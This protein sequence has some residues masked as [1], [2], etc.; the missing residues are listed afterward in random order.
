R[1]DDV[2]REGEAE[3]DPGKEE[4]AQIHVLDS[5]GCDA[6]VGFSV[7]AVSAPT[8]MAQS[9]HPASVTRRQ[10]RGTSTPNA[11]SMTWKGSG[12]SPARNVLLDRCENKFIRSNSGSE[13]YSGGRDLFSGRGRGGE[14][15]SA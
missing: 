10:I 9:G 8:R 6:S 7:A 15:W 5:P 4:V 2:E 11:A 13:K 3:L 14:N 1:E 12:R